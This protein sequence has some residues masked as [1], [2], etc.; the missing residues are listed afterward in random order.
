MDCGSTC[1]N[2]SSHN[3]KD[4]L[5]LDSPSCEYQTVPQQTSLE[6]VAKRLTSPPVTVLYLCG[7]E[8]KREG[9]PFLAGS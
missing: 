1:R 5:S 4:L 8:G 7:E 3:I 2:S 9:I 6:S